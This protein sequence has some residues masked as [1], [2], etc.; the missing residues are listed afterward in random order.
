[1]IFQTSEDVSKK[2]EEK[3]LARTQ[4]NMN[5]TFFKRTG[6]LNPFII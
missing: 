4:L 2:K 6:D 1:M 5:F 3:L